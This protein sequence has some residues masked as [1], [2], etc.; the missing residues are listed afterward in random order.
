MT[1]MELR[2][3]EYRTSIYVRTM[4][5]FYTFNQISHGPVVSTLTLCSDH[6]GTRDHSPEWQIHRAEHFPGLFG[7]FPM[8]TKTKTL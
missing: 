7:N 5:H 6:S 4:E 2:R 3:T 1:W 8:A